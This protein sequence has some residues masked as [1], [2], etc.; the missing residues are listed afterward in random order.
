MPRLVSVKVAAQ[1][2]SDYEVRHGRKP[3]TER[4]VR[5]LIDVGRLP[6]HRIPWR[7]Q[8]GPT[9]GLRVRLNW[10]YLKAA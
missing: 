6:A 9:S 4:H 7:P 10:D 5:Y 3:I 1:I 2:L 8:R